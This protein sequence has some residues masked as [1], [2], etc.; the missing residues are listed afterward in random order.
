MPIYEY[1]C[2]NCQESFSLLQK[3]GASVEGTSCPRCGS[4]EVTRQ[5][6]ACAVGGSSN[7]S[8]PSCSMGG[9]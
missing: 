5:I 8:G 7:A 6:S 9:G 2:N 3:M 1:R 4:P